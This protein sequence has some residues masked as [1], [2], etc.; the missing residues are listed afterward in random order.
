MSD[1]SVSS[2][3]EFEDV[4]PQKGPVPKFSSPGRG[5]GDFPI[6]IE[7]KKINSQQ[8]GLITLRTTMRSYANE[9][10][11]LHSIH[12]VAPFG[13]AITV[14]PTAHA[15]SKPESAI[16]R[17]N[18]VF[19]PGSPGQSNQY[20]T[21]TLALGIRLPRKL[22]GAHVSELAL[23][24]LFKGGMISFMKRRLYARLFRLAAPSISWSEP[25]D[26]AS[27]ASAP[28]AKAEAPAAVPEAAA[29]PLPPPSSEVPKPSEPELK[30]NEEDEGE[31]EKEL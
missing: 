1:S 20:N 24:F 16:G 15:L 31:E 21:H 12:V 11:L 14:G 4:S 8:Q 27:A 30:P 19:G 18:V 5:G 13:A 9:R 26:N 3:Q 23:R 7:F 10:L 17:P 25:K 28:S 22:E 2:W 29:P 6:E